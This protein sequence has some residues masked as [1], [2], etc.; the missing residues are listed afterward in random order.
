MQH[1]HHACVSAFLRK[2]IVAAVGHRDA[3]CVYA[4]ALLF[5]HNMHQ[6]Y[7]CCSLLRKR[8]GC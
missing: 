1:D 2:R 8:I 3:C 7:V 5:A 6:A 4:A